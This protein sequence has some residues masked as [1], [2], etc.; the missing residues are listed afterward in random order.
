MLQSGNGCDELNVVT[1]NTVTHEGSAKVRATSADFWSDQFGFAPC[2]ASANFAA[3]ERD[4]R[5]RDYAG[6]PCRP[7]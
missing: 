5:V 2:E 3:R 1:A 4:P 6:F 7:I